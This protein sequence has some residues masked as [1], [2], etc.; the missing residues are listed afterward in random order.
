MIG[1]GYSPENIFCY[2][3]ERIVVGGHGPY[4]ELTKEAF[5]Q[6]ENALYISSNA[7]WRLAPSYVEKV[8]YIE[9]RLSGFASIKIYKQLRPVTYADYK[10]GM[11]YV[12]FYKIE[13]G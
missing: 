1:V 9:Y 2:G 8:K 11:Y 10:V 3:Y 7:S 4:I 13:C 6:D 5:G 12:D